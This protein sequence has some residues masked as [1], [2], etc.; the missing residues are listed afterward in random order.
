MKSTGR[1]LNPFSERSLDIFKSSDDLS[2]HLEVDPD[3]IRDALLDSEWLLFEFVEIHSWEIELQI[4]A[5]I[6]AQ[7]QLTHQHTA[8]VTVI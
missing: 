3:L 4:L 2:L 6:H 8:G 7:R 1:T 5:P